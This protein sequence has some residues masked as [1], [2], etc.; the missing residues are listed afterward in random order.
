MLHAQHVLVNRVHDE[1]RLHAHARSVRR[2]NTL[3]LLSNETVR[4]VRR[5]G[6][7]VPDPT[8]WFKCRCMVRRLRARTEQG[9]W[10]SSSCV[11]S[12]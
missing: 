10:G 9:Q 12:R 1:R 8:Q 4:N 6:A 3:D 5:T 11:V 2:I 7:S